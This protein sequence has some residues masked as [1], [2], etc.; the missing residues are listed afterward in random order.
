MFL[1]TKHPA[2]D[3]MLCCILRPGIANS[4]QR[5]CVLPVPPPHA[6]D[7]YSG[8]WSNSLETFH[9]LR[10]IHIKIKLN[11]CC[12]QNRKPSS[13]EIRKGNVIFGNLRKNEMARQKAFLARHFRPDFP[14]AVSARIDAVLAQFQRVQSHFSE[15]NAEK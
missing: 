13:H 7:V 2:I 14:N 12:W 15:K 4:P 11:E 8:C 1:T 3:E 9:I 6:Q 10:Q 5:P